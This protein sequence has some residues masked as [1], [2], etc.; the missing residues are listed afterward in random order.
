MCTVWAEKEGPEI[1]QF[2]VDPNEEGLIFDFAV[3]KLK[4]FCKNELKPK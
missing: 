1:N 4:K 3:N 2:V